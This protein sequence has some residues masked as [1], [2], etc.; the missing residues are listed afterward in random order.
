MKKELQ[1]YSVWLILVILWNF[2]YPSALPI[3]DVI[4]AII[5]SI[6]V[7]ILNNYIKKSKEL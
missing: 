7:K 5:L 3:Y 1:A 4:V 2:G 6:V